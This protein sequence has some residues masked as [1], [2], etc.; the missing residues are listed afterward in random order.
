MSATAADV[1][2]LPTPAPGERVSDIF[3][4][5]N[6]SI[7]VKAGLFGYALK[8]NGEEICIFSRFEH[9]AYFARVFIRA[10]RWGLLRPKAGI[11]R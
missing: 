4:P 5:K 9:A 3:I 1:T 11:R 10:E 8:V 7:S 6:S 2:R